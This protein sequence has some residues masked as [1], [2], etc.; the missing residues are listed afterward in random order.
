MVEVIAWRHNGHV[1][2]WYLW[3][4]N[5][6]VQQFLHMHMWRH[7]ITTI[8]L[9]SVWQTTHKFL[10]RSLSSSSLKSL[11]FSSKG[12][13][14]DSSRVF[15]IFLNLGIPGVWRVAKYA[16]IPCKYL[17]S[18]PKPTVNTFTLNTNCV[19]AIKKAL[20]T[21]LNRVHLPPGKQYAPAVIRFWSMIRQPR[22][23]LPI[24]FK[25]L[26]TPFNACANNHPD[27]EKKAE[28]PCAKDRKMKVMSHRT[29]WPT[30]RKNCPIAFINDW[31]P[32]SSIFKRYI[33]WCQAETEQVWTVF[34]TN[35]IPRKIDV[36]TVHNS[37]TNN[38]PVFHI[39]TKI[40][41]MTALMLVTRVM[42]AELGVFKMY[43]HPTYDCCKSIPVV[44]LADDAP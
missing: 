38:T 23:H 5:N 16:K 29:V 3:I 21:R 7:G 43:F 4:R 1:R 9:F 19:Y 33:I 15:T 35:S 44:F 17:S 32:Y 20:E 27:I 18:S 14:C 42:R 36:V 40:H 25:A 34:P 28:M 24:S 41:S 39:D 2:L 11:S 22:S 12:T 26:Y 6:S 13:S 8:L 30:N 10:S 31:N 37:S